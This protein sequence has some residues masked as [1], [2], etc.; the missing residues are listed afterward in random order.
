MHPKD[1]EASHPL[2]GP[3]PT[4]PKSPK[5]EDDDDDVDD[6]SQEHE[7]I[8]I[9]GRSVLGVQYVMEET[10]QGLVKAL[11]P[12]DGQPSEGIS[13]G[14]PSCSNAP[15]IPSQATH[16]DRQKPCSRRPAAFILSRTFNLSRV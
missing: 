2:W 10:P 14:L 3:R 12:V 6:V 5:T 8:H 9:S 4:Y 7:G 15:A 16:S 1:L 13:Q 11:G